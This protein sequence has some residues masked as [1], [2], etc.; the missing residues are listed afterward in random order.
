MGANDRRQGLSSIVVSMAILSIWVALDTS[1]SKSRVEPQREVSFDD[2]TVVVPRNGLGAALPEL[3]SGS[4]AVDARGVK[5]AQCG[6]SQDME[7]ERALGAK[8][9]IL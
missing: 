2:E 4:D 3:G 6:A 7:R 1:W 9:R 5:E 8:R